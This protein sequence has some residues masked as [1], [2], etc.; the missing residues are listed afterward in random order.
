MTTGNNTTGLETLRGELRAIKFSGSDFWSIAEIVTASG[1]AIAKGKLVG[2][3]VGDSVELTGGWSDYKGSREFKF[4]A[5]RVVLPADNSGIVGW[6]QAKLPAIGRARATALVEKFGAALWEVIEKRPD[7]LLAVEGITPERLEKIVAAYE[8]HRKDRDRMIGFKT[9]GLTDN[10]IAKVLKTL[11]DD[12]EKQL[13]KNPYVLSKLVHGFGFKRADVVAL[14]MG[15]PLDAP[16]RI[17]AALLFTLSEAATNGHTCMPSGALVR[18]SNTVLGELDSRT[19]I[20]E[21]ERCLEDGEFVTRRRGWVYLNHL[22]T[23]EQSV[24]AR[25]FALVRGGGGG[26][27]RRAA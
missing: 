19:V 4:R 18:M 24:A 3:R 9:W 5:V 20:A 21:Y 1:V 16:A 15:V 13:K 27:E 25:L 26:E 6:L 11:G 17:R 10:Q 14:R 8:A 22:D 7:E 12:A 2:A 23:A